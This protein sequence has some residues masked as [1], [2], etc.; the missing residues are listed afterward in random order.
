MRNL[1][2]QVAFDC[3]FSHNIFG[4]NSFS[5]LSI[6]ESVCEK[7]VGGGVPEKKKEEGGVEY[8]LFGRPPSLRRR[9]LPQIE[10]KRG[11]GGMLALR[12]WASC[13]PGG[14]KKKEKRNGG[15][16]GLGF[17]GGNNGLGI[18]GGTV[19]RGKSLRI[20]PL[21]RKHRARSSTQT[22]R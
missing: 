18:K 21:H 4:R 16:G 14:P 7:R 11:E 13:R 10:K 3:C 19:A 8:L 12:F 22:S 9:P 5:S 6:H 17:G 20:L 2:T 1:I 15:E